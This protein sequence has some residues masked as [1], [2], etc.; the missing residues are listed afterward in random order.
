MKLAQAWDAFVVDYVTTF[1]P[2]QVNPFSHFVNLDIIFKFNMFYFF[3]SL[4]GSST[5]LF[6]MSVDTR[7]KYKYGIINL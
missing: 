5:D 4:M 2:C 1:K 6:I 3:K 7:P